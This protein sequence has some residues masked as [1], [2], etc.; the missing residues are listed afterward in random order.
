MPHP[1]K[2]VLWRPTKAKRYFIAHQLF[3]WSIEVM[4]NIS[5]I[6]ASID[7]ENITSLQDLGFH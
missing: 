1:A 4:K 6:S 3:K 5:L 2:E 7:T